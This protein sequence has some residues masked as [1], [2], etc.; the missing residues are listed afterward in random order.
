VKDQDHFNLFAV[1]ANLQRVQQ[2]ISLV[3]ILE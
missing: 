3:P 1:C 2:L